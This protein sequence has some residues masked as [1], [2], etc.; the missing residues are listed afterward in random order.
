VAPVVPVAAVAPD[1]NRASIT[2]A[3]VTTTNAIPA[4]N[5]RAAIARIP[6]LRCYR[7]A[8]RGHGAA[9]SGTATLRLKID[10]GGYVT[11]ATL[12]DAAFLPAL[13]GCIETAARTLRVKDVDTGEGSAV[14]TIRFVIS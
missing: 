8:L 13:K 2:V 11:A 9:A 7:E 5:I 3:T 6:I 10:V 12:E 1:P 14:V 4:S